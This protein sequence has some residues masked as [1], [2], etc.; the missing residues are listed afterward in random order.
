MD[1]HI[2]S[3]AVI[4]TSMLFASIPSHAADINKCTSQSGAVTLTDEA[5]PP[6]TRAVKLVSAPAE[7]EPSEAPIVAPS[8]RVPTVE[9]FNSGPMPLRFS[10]PMRSPAPAR[11]MSLDIATLKAAKANL[12]LFDQSAPR[13]QRLAGL[14]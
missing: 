5:C 6:N 14:P 12:H 10:A 9:R 7:A 4:F 2:A 8:A 1:R 11:G 3:C 13:S